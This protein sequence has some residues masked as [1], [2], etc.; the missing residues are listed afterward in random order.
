VALE[1]AVQVV[2][3]LIPALNPN[4]PKASHLFLYRNI[5]FCYSLDSRDAFPQHGGDNAAHY[6]AGKDF[7]VRPPFFCPF[8][9]IKKQ[10]ADR[11]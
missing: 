2:K 7:A 10:T 5:F 1:G 6:A 4:E 9:I 3:G 11:S 8:A